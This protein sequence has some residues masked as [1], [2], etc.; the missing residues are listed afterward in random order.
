MNHEQRSRKSG[1]VG[2]YEVGEEIRSSANDPAQQAS[3]P[4]QRKT[5]ESDVPR[6]QVV[7]QNAG[8]VGD[9]D[10]MTGGDSGDAHP[11]DQAI[12]NTGL[13]TKHGDSAEQPADLS[14]LNPD[15]HKEDYTA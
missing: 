15:P 1:E 3:T 4:T 13:A 9:A 2:E 14:T 10:A 12:R 7:G 5:N 11:D 6:E 8:R